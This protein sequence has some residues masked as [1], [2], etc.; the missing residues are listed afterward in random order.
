VTERAEEDET[1]IR[2]ELINPPVPMEFNR[3]V[4]QIIVDDEEKA[5]SNSL[6]FLAFV[7]RI[8]LRDTAYLI[9]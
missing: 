4:L 1:T 5:K 7:D 2:T 6:E 3:E 9:G 8:G